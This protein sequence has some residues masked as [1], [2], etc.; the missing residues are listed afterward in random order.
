MAKAG[1]GGV[2]SKLMKVMD[3]AI[4][5][6]FVNA[7]EASYCA[8]MIVNG[9]PNKVSQE[10]E[11]NISLANQKLQEQFDAFDERFV[12]MAKTET[13]LM[14]RSKKLT[15]QLKDHAHQVSTALARMDSM[16]GV[17]FE[18]RLVF[19]ERFVAA[20]KTLSEL[21]ANGSLQKIST[22]MASK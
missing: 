20:A 11:R 10:T 15:S 6:P 5:E 3:R 13:E 2:M 14:E 19:L 16:V 22:A 1:F 17:D 9:R 18:R 21:E 8:E 7:G 12:R 4:A